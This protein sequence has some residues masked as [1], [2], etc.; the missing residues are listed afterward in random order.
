MSDKNRFSFSNIRR[1]I[2]KRVDELA[3]EP[4]D[5]EPK[6]FDNP[7]GT[8]DDRRPYVV[9]N[10]DFDR[11]EAPKDDM[12]KYWRQYETTPIVRKPI[13]SFAS[14]VVEPGYYIEADHLND[15]QKRELE[16]WLERCA[17]LEGKFGRDW[18][19]MAKKAV[20]QREVRGTVIVEKVPDKD[21]PDALAAFKFLNPESI[22]IVTRP[23][24]SILI[25]PD[26]VNIYEDVPTTDDGRGAAYLQEITETGQT[27]WGQPVKGDDDGDGK[28]EFAEDEII[29]L[30]RDAD[31][32][33]VF[34]TSRV[35]AVSDR[36]EGMRQKLSDNDEAIASKA[37]PLWLFKFGDPDAPWERDDI[38]NFMEEHEVSNFHPGMKQGVR[39][40]V[41]VETISGEVAEIAEYLN[42]DI[43]YIISA[44]PMPKYALGGFS[45]S[46]GQIAGIA[47]QQDM[48]RQIK[49]ARQEIEDEFT[50]SIQEKAEQ[51]GLP[52]P[53]DIKI[54]IGDPERPD[55]VQ[56]GNEQIIR[57]LGKD[58]QGNP[59]GSTQ[60][61]DAPDENMP[62]DTGRSD[63]EK[64]R[65]LQKVLGSDELWKDEAVA[66]L[67]MNDERQQELADVIYQ[68]FKLARDDIIKSVGRAYAASENDAIRT[69]EHDAN[70]AVVKAI[71]QAGVRRACRE[72]IRQEL[73]EV[74][75]ENNALEQSRF[76]NDE[77]SSFYATNITNATRDAMDEMM[78]HIRVQLRKGAEQ[79]DK[80]S[81]INARISS[82][83]SEKQLRSRSELIA[84]M[85][86]KR[87]REST[88][89]QEFEKNENIIGVKVVNDDPHS[90][91]CHSLNGAKLYFGE[92]DFSEQLME[93]TR[94]E[95]VPDEFNPLPNTPPFHFGCTTRFEPIYK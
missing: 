1:G 37:Y 7:G 79:G 87:L 60:R 25:Q 65:R 21:D 12:R 31:V 43:D 33:E 19:Q 89:L 10:E 48:Q 88:K 6:S 26:D 8:R 77:Y 80:F 81:N 55:N 76:L 11:T 18:L 86:L 49:E 59:E 64:Q 47:Q 62:E 67:Q 70:R 91:V 5:A 83:Y 39:G 66:E 15:E 16:R 61:Q 41:S 29:K 69:F 93:Q 73:N 36:I 13:S 53:E 20:V 74:R 42:F 40:D 71:T 84:H 94:R 52:Q 50:P 92:G 32:G 24:Q 27:W 23:K 63:E 17:I 4:E 72:P 68:A 45:D 78:R 54:K 22:E 51:L 85:E 95:Y 56:D 14:Q 30:T 58:A 9:E 2:G 34:G 38:R 44:M 35:E 57:Y 90:M 75:E 46:V 82:K 28:V 3:G